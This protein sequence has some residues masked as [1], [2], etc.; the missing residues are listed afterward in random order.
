MKY[1]VIASGSKGNLIY[2]EGKDA[3]ILIDA[4]ITLKSAK[5]RTSIDFSKIDALLVTH[6]H[7]DHVSNLVTYLRKLNVTC[8]VS[9]ESFTEIIR[10]RPQ[11]NFEGVKVAFI[12]GNTKYKIN[13]LTF[14]PLY[15]SH[16][17]VNCFGFIFREDGK[18]LAYIADTGF[19]PTPYVEMLKQ[20]DHIIIEA[21]HDIR[22]L[23]ESTRPRVLKNRILSIEG[24]MSNVLCGEILSEILKSGNCKMI[25]LAHLSEEC[26]T[27]ENAVDTVI[28]KIKER[29][30]PIIRVAKQHEALEMVEI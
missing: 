19:I 9:K 7:S 3:R 21:N 12:E 16:D 6:E 11:D 15:L 20:V 1:Q 28:D 23:E 27:P 29:Y 18:T 24:H 17:T 30:I 5:E 4:G 10:K 14:M 22:M 26:N 2:V 25:T 13:S 8:Y